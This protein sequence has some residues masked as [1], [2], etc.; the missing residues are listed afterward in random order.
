MPFI[1]AAARGEGCM[2]DGL[3]VSCETIEFHRSGDETGFFLSPSHEYSRFVGSESRVTTVRSEISHKDFQKLLSALRY[4][5]I[6]TPDAVQAARERLASQAIAFMA[7]PP[8]EGG[9]LHQ[10]DLVTQAAE[11][12]AYPFEAA[13]DANEKWLADAADGVVITRRVR[14][15]LSE[16]MPTWPIRPRVLFAHAACAADLERA[17]IEEHRKALETALEPWVGRAGDYRDLLCVKEVASFPELAE[18]RAAFAPTYVHL[19]AHGA[20]AVPDAELEDERIWGLRLGYPGEPGVR[21]ADIAAALCANEAAPLVVT[22]AACDAANQTQFWYAEHSVVHEL[23]CRGIPVVIGSQLPLTKAGSV[24]LASAF[25]AR[26]LCGRDVRE[27]LHAARVALRSKPDAGHDWLS[28]VGYVR[29]PSEGYARYL[30]EVGLEAELGMLRAAQQRADVLSASGTDPAEFAAVDALVCNRRDSLADRRP[31]LD[32]FR[33]DLLDECDGLLASACKRRAELLFR[34]TQRIGGEQ[35]EG[36]LRTSREELAQSLARY[37]SVYDDNAQSHW[38]GMQQLALEAVLEGA[39]S[40]AADWDSVRVVAERARDRNPKDY[41]CGGTLAEIWL[42]AP[43]A[44]RP[45]DLEAAREAFEL[46]RTRAP[47]GEKRAFAIEST[48]RQ[49][50]RYVDW[51]T[52]ANGFFPGRGDLREDAQQLLAL[53][54]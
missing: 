30:M 51:W 11:L 38:H 1:A 36:D 25:Y 2:G 49:L 21:P 28:L 32:S 6:G 27:A 45:R 48:R 53:L 3:R 29:L 19:L 8:F 34:R 39:F 13:Y 50:G 23:H 18:A 12:W 46:L 17:L 15:N 52:T 20:L 44:G 37:R 33:R 10:I 40:R 41:W 7:A 54:P 5:R 16:S 42:L 24:E 35:S 26:L 43:I 4:T 9:R 47:A 22:L 14:M 31:T